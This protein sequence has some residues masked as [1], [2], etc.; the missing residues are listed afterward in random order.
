MIAAA[1]QSKLLFNWFD[2]ALVL[3][4]G[5]GFWRGRKNG[6]TKEFIPFF[7]WLFIV[8][9]AGFGYQLLG[10]QLIQSG[11]IRKMF[12]RSFSENTAAYIISY[13]LLA[14]L[15]AVAFLYVRKLLKPKLEGS[16]IFGSSEY[17]LGMVSGTLRYGCM[18][19]FG[20]ALLH[21]P[22]YTSAEIAARKAYENRWYGGGLKGYSGDFIPSVDEAQ[23]TIFHDSL[24]G[25]FIDKGLNLLLINSAP[26]AAS[27]PPVMNIQQ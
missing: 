22:H 21:A 23:A 20:L 1:T 9:I 3:I 16:N 14:G 8:L 13:L 24:F 19:I 5:F 12:G 18:T 10:K 15:V 26:N 17:Y 25:P 27:K 4:L 7:C 2:L 6:M 11:I